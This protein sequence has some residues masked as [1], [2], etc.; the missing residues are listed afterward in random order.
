MKKMMEDP[1]KADPF[2]LY[3]FG[4]VGYFDLQTMLIFIFALLSILALPSMYIFNSYSGILEPHGFARI[5]LG[6]MGASASKCVQSAFEANNLVISCPSST[7]ISEVY[8]FG[9]IDSSDSRRDTCNIKA[10]SVYDPPYI[11]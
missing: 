2:L 5:S 3:G 11:C 10:G 6:N 1:E 9:V 4:M 8:S 7:T